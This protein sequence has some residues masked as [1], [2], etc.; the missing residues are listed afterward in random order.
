VVEA[1]RRR[2]EI[3]NRPARTGPERM[4]DAFMRVVKRI[5]T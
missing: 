3:V 2:R 1:G 4:R 5:V